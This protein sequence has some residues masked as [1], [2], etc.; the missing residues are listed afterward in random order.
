MNIT[1]SPIATDYYGW[2]PIH[3]ASRAGHLDFVK[4]LV[5]FTD[6]PNA[7][8]EKTGKTPIDLA[9]AQR[10]NRVAKFLEEYRDQNWILKL[11]RTKIFKLFKI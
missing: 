9:M 2:T 3:E 8:L 10:H 1:A 5:N 4:Y 7:P 6:D 11:V